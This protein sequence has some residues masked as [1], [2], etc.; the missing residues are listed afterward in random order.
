L[1]PNGQ[2]DPIIVA[3]KRLNTRGFQVWIYTTFLINFSLC[4][5]FI[6]MLDFVTVSCYIGL[7]L[8]GVPI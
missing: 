3:I 2:G 8:S 6:I 1:P 5:C 7:I 4:Y